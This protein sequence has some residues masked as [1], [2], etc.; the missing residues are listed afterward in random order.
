[1]L[2]VPLDYLED[3]PVGSGYWYS[4]TASGYWETV[5]DGL[6][7]AVRWVGGSSM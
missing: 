2:R 7:P 1:M 5:V 3:H 4:T 6:S